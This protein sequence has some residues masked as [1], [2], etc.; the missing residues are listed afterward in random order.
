[1]HLFSSSF[2]TIFSSSAPPLTR[3]LLSP[4]YLSSLPT[5]SLLQC[6][7]T[8]F[9]PSL[10]SLGGEEVRMQI[11]VECLRPF[12]ESVPFTVS[13][14]TA[15]QGRHSYALTVRTVYSD[16]TC[17]AQPLPIL[18]P[19][20]PF[21][22]LY[23]Y[24]SLSSSITTSVSVSPF[25]TL[26]SLPSL[27]SLSCQSLQP[28]SSS[29]CPQRRLPTWPGGKHWKGTKPRS[30]RYCRVSHMCVSVCVSVSVC[31]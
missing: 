26:P 2:L 8:A 14:T 13:F 27:P 24:D 16:S 28:P 4:F 17:A 15:T 18:T 20:L 22:E 9:P 10:P 19:T 25:H 1:M 23:M 7:P 11:A 29:R 5:P 3:C 30:R 6:F 12:C 31:V 21:F